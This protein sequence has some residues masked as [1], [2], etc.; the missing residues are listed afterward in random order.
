MVCRVNG[1]EVPCPAWVEKYAPIFP[2]VLL[3]VMILTMAAVWKVFEKAGKPGW[4][5]IV[6]IYNIVTLMRIVGLPLWML[7]L[8]FIPVVNLLLAIYVMYGLA[9]RFGKGAFFALVPLPANKAIEPLQITYV[10]TDRA[11]NR[12]TLTVDMSK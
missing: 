9:Q 5:A 2:P 8:L 4:A 10:L 6:P 7:L 12:T 1:K 11:H 3:V